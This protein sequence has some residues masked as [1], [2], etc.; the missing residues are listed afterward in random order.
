M[1]N[2]LPGRDSPQ[3]LGNADSVGLI[4]DREG[5]YNNMA[6]NIFQRIAD[7]LSNKIAAVVPGSSTY[8]VQPGDSLSAIAKS[9][10]GDGSRWPEIF[11]ANRDKIDDANLIHPGQK[12]TIP[13]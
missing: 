12:L 13:K 4:I 10:Y 3:F 11:A 7:A 6:K 2:R 9:V 8:V 1:T 5:K